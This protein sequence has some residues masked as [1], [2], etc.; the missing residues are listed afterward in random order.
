MSALS[1]AS[2]AK[3]QQAR[4]E[5][6]A[7]ILRG[8]RVSTQEELRRLLAREGFAVN[9][10]TLSRDLAQLGARRVALPAGGTA[11]ELEEAVD[12]SST[13]EALRRLQ[14]LIRSVEDNG[15]LVVIQTLPGAASAIAAAID[16]AALPEALATLA[17]DDTIFLAPRKGA[18]AA[19]AA[20]RLKKLWEQ[21]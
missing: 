10:A 19:A 12:P 7:K 20:K 16:D 2:A 14:A 9:Q 5:A 3:A 17:G 6:I 15:A 1:F 11:Y 4:R 21:A 13:K 8:Q 18:S